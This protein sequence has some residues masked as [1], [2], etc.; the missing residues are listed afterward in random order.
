MVQ[1]Q[2]VDCNCSI[3]RTV[4]NNCEKSFIILNQMISK[5]M[6]FDTSIDEFISDN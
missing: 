4:L 1:F 5:T 3:T 2:M 6:S